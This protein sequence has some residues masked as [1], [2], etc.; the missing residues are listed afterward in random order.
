[1]SAKPVSEAPTPPPPRAAP[2][3]DVAG[4]KA[5]LDGPE[6]PTRD[7][8]R[9][10]LADARFAY[11]PGI[12]QGAYRELVLRWL[13]ILSEAG[14]GALGVPQEFGG[15]G[16]PRGFLAAFET[17]AFH[18]LSLTI[19]YGVQF[20]LFQ[21]SVQLLGTRWH[22][23]RFLPAISRGE[24]LGVFAMSELGHGSNVRE[25]ETTA[26]YDAATCEFV[27]HTPRHEAH[28][29]WLGNAAQHGRMATVFAQ[30]IVNGKREGVHALLVP[31]RNE[32]DTPCNGVRL[33]DTGAKEGLNGVDN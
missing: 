23:E 22:H 1:M 29:E 2:P 12:E 11:H 32:D 20:G 8:M 16:D 30:L 21:G 10:L 18:D 26:T 33:E 25:L 3:V 7:R 31:I 15:A 19:K 13:G 4:L 14:F 9:A 24:L 6:A 5:L 27:I 28:K 17:L